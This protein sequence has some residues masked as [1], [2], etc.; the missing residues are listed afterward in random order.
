MKEIKNPTQLSE[1]GEFGLIQRLTENI[2][3]KN[4]STHKGVGDDAAGSAGLE[5]HRSKVLQQRLVVVAVGL[6]H[7]PAEGTELVGQRVE[8][9]G[10]FGAVT[11]LEAVPVDDANE[12]VQAEV[13]GR[14]GR[15]PH[16]TLLEFAVAGEHE[17]A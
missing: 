12:L 16:R 6:V 14:H 2:Q 11:L 13:A 10:R 5:G 8:A 15:F 4:S 7:G 9:H 1:L 17:G 3:I